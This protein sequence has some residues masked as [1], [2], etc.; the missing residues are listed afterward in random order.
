[1]FPCFTKSSLGSSSQDVLRVI[2]LLICPQVHRSFHISSMRKAARPVVSI[3][4]SRK[5]SAS[6][7]A[8]GPPTLPP[9]TLAH[10]FSV[11]IS[12]TRVRGR[13]LHKAKANRLLCPTQRS[14]TLGFPFL[15]SSKAKRRF[16]AQ[17][18]NVQLS[19]THRVAGKSSWKHLHLWLKLQS[20]PATL[21]CSAPSH[22]GFSKI[23]LHCMVSLT[24]AVSA[25]RHPSSSWH[26]PAAS[27]LC[28]NR[29]F[30]SI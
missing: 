3:L 25:H 22:I 1:M 15:Q 10:W 4:Q 20:V 12:F 2:A 29:A 21:S 18:L 13:D 6:A 9:A 28:L 8:S 24:E 17:I 14:S 7:N 30:A 11:R 16:W 19:G 5:G 26:L 23:H 27:R